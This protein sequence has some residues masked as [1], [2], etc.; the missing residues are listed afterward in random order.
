[1]YTSSTQ[2]ESSFKK[3]YRFA[4]FTRKQSLNRYNLLLVVPVRDIVKC[5]YIVY[6]LITMAFPVSLFAQKGS[7]AITTNKSILVAGDE[8]KKGGYLV[9]VAQE[10]F[11]QVGYSPEFIFVPWARALVQSIKGAYTVLLA[12]YYTKE[13]AEELLYSDPI[14]TTRVF[15][16]K[17]KVDKITYKTMEDLKPYR[18][19]HIRGSK[20]S[21]EFDK[22]E[23]TFLTIEYAKSTEQN[24]KKLLAHRLDL[25]VE[26]EERLKELLNTEFKGEVDKLEFLYPPLQVNTYHNCVSKKLPEGQ[27]IIADFNRGLKKIRVNGTYNAILKKY[28]IVPENVP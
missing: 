8:E 5:A 6:L 28:G 9:E 14:G 19:G 4:V 26:K 3:D 17:R 24:I 23:K 20:V 10:A 2:I 12:A 25:V 11:Q 18:I 27:Q 7:A 22:V 15:L 13:R 1:M 21:P 16:F